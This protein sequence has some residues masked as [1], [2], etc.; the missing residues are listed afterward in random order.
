MSGRIQSKSSIRKQ[1]LESEQDQYAT[2]SFLRRQIR[3][4]RYQF[5]KWLHYDSTGKVGKVW[6]ILT[7][8]QYRHTSRPSRLLVALP[9][10]M[11]GS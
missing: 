4:T 5:A 6:R 11:V 2:Q 10:E 7:T 8:D 1:G 3:D 9:Q